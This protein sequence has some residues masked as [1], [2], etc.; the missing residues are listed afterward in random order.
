MTNALIQNFGNIHLLLTNFLKFCQCFLFLLFT[1]SFLI[2]NKITSLGD[3]PIK[4]SNKFTIE[5]KKK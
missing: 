2:L 4:K 3:V 1:V 5:R